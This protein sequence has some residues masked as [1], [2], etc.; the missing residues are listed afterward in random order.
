MYFK[1]CGHWIAGQFLLRAWIFGHLFISY[2]GL[3][4]NQ[5]FYYVKISCLLKLIQRSEC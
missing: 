5:E 4:A 2:H 3:S 1:G